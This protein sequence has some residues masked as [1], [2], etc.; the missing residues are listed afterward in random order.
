MSE[1]GAID[2]RRD[3]VDAEHE[4]A[5]VAWHYYVGGLTQ[6]EIADKLGL[7]RLKVNRIVGQARADGSVRIDILLPLARCVELEERLKTAYGLKDARVVPS[8]ADQDAQQRVIG[9]AAGAMLEPLLRGGRG[10]GV[11][12]GRTLSAAVKR[13]TPQ[14]LEAAWVASLM[15]GLTRGSGAN[16][17]E[18]ATE[19]ARALGAECYYLA[20]PIYCPSPESRATL[21]THYGLAEAVRRARTAEV[22]LVAAG[23]LSARSLLASTQIVAENLEALVAAGAVGDLLGVFLD[24]EGRPV[25][26]PLN[27]RV[28]ALPPDEL[29]AIPSSILASGGPH[30]AAVVRAVM[31]A[32]YV[33][34]LVTDETVAES[35]L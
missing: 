28:I 15:G 23:D 13:L 21:M 8:I 33:N 11:G 35:L 27:A 5:R 25:D 34:R 2:V 16:T 32:G 24:A 10:F 4:R 17:F 12:W 6:Q 1:R 14:R 29:K 22:A 3:G 30:K 19:F 7:T 18:V 26:H 20:A 31:T 9:E